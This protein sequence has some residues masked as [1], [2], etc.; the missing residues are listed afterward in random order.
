VKDQIFDSVISQNGMGRLL[1]YSGKHPQIIQALDEVKEWAEGMI[2][3]ARSNLPRLPEINFR[4]ID[5]AEINAAA[6]ESG[7]HYFIGL[8]SAAVAALRIVINRFMADPEIFQEIGDPSEELPIHKKAIGSSFE[9]IVQ[10]SIDFP[11]PRN[12]IRN[13]YAGMLYRQSVRFLLGHEIAHIVLGHVDYQ[14]QTHGVS[15]LMEA[16][17]PAEARFDGFALEGQCMEIDAD[18]R[19]IYARMFTARRDWEAATNQRTNCSKCGM[20]PIN[21]FSTWDLQ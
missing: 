13:I 21:C 19:S 6:F 17:R 15:S 1:D 8:T 18:R 12:K 10:Q 14:S 2:T 11:P 5:G 9:G 4:F 7:N 16:K 3:S 20:N